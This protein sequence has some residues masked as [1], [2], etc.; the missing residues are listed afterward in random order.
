MLLNTAS[1]V[2]SPP[3]RVSHLMITS[4]I[5]FD[6]VILGLMTDFNHLGHRFADL[7]KKADPQR[8]KDATE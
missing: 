3:F 1:H 8:L 2:L 6:Y 4:T 7:Y 5:S